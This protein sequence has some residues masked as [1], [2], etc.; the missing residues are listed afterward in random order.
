ME[1]PAQRYFCNKCG[2]VGNVDLHPGCGYLAYHLAPFEQN[3]IDQLEREL[4]L[5]K[6]SPASVP[7]GFTM[8]EPA[9]LPDGSGFGTMTEREAALL[10]KME[11]QAERIKELEEQAQSLARSVMCDQVSNDSHSLFLAAIRDLA[12]INECLGLDPDD[13]GAVPIIDAIEAQSAALKLAKEALG[14]VQDLISESHGVYGLHLNGDESPWSE[15]EQGGRFERLT[16]L[17]EALAAID[18]LKGE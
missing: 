2:Y 11:R 13:G 4:A 14:E 9:I 12:A 17:P 3:Y 10:G 1:R 15:I 5:L 6:A 16:T 18:A 8:S 7:E